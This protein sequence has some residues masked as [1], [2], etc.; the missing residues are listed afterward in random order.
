MPAGPF[1]CRWGAG[2]Q[3]YIEEGNWEVQAVLCPEGD[4]QYD[5]CH[6][7]NESRRAAND[8]A[9]IFIEFSADPFP[10]AFDNIRMAAEMHIRVAPAFFRR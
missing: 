9:A 3:G 8:Q 7:L 4:R 2:R 5:S 1:R 10:Y 6:R